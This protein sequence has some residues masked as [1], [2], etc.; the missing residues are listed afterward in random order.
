MVQMRYLSVVMVV[1]TFLASPALAEPDS[2]KNLASFQ[3]GWGNTGG[4]YQ[5]MFQNKEYLIFKVRERSKPADAD[6][7]LEPDSLKAF[8]AD[9][10]RFKRA[11]NPL[12]SEGFQVFSKLEKDGA[13]LQEVFAYINGIPMKAV[14]VIQMRDGKKYEHVIALDKTSYTGILQGMR[15]AKKKLGWR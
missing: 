7:V 14:Q 10:V 12:K 4:Y 8:E 5:V 11:N 13:V 3:D 9:L 2:V 6:F 1:L 15:S